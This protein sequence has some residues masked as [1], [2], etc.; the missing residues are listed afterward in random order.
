MTSELQLYGPPS[1]PPFWI[2]GGAV[3]VHPPTPE[4][5]TVN[6]YIRSNE[7]PFVSSTNPLQVGN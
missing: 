5:V 2:P 1:G 6:F 7:M 3:H 4:I